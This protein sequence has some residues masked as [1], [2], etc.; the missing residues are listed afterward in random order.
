M[1]DVFADISLSE[2]ETCM[3]LEQEIAAKE[4]R[5]SGT[6]GFGRARDRLS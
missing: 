1:D 2:E 3:I 5:R 4:A 6:V